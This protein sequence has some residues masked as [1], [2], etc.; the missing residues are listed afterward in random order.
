MK[1]DAVAMTLNRIVSSGDQAGRYHW[2]F[3]A[4]GTPTGF[5]E[6]KAAIRAAL[7]QQGIHDTTNNSPHITLSYCAQ[8][9]QQSMKIA[10]IT[11]TIDELLLVKGGGDPYRYDVLGSWPLNRSNV[12]NAPQLALL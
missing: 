2:S 5:A 11:W 1:A 4:K 9:K 10:P 6:L 8:R 12:I 3:Q 7:A